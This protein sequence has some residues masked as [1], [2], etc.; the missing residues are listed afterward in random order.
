MKH[1]LQD[2]KV[3]WATVTLTH[4]F[5]HILQVELN[6]AIEV[7]GVKTQ[8]NADTDDFVSSYTVQF[9]TTGMHFYP[10]KEAGVDKVS[11]VFSVKHL[12]QR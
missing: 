11:K 12:I 1:K 6:S 3:G 8:G 5:V 10:V 4:L 7:T 9:S 2:Y